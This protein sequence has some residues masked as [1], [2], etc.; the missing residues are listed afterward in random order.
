[1]LQTLHIKGFR[2]IRDL[3]M[4]D[5]APVTV[6]TGEN[7]AGKT[8]VLEAALA[9]C[10]RENPVWIANLQAHRGFDVVTPQGPNYSGLF[11]GP[12]DTG[13]ASISAKLADGKTCRV[14]LKRA[15]TGAILVGKERGSS[16][17]DIQSLPPEL[18]C[19]AYEGK[20]LKR[21]S[22][23]ICEIKPPNQLALRAEGAKVA[24]PY[25]VLMHPTDRAAGSEEQQRFGQLVLE[26][27]HSSIVDALHL[28]D[29]R[30]T[31]V[32]FLPTSKGNYFVVKRDGKIAPLGLLGGGINGLFGFIINVAFARGGF[33]GID[34]VE[35]GFHHSLH[36]E[37]FVR[38]FEAANRNNTQLFL[39]THSA[40]ALRALVDAATETKE[41]DFAVVHLRREKDDAIFAKV[42]RE[43]DAL[44]SLD[45]G[46]E[47]R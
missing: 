6:F 34:E 29:E 46:Y 39:T 38:L 2:G 28:F 41:D 43:H 25:S 30:I 3:E 15:K 9:I 37:V 11:Y 35:N 18:I 32:Q 1:M 7:G 47:L 26:G 42:F 36:R 33:V 19:E 4:S 40:E 10:G 23:L 44:A 21:T 16:S 24:E 17:T 20:V 14:K 27:H 12:S 22:R 31:D 45:L 5:L 13:T 8:T